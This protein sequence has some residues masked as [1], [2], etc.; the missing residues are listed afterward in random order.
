MNFAHKGQKEEGRS[1]HEN[2]SAGSSADEGAA[3]AEAA[4]LPPGRQYAG[5]MDLMA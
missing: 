4:Q 1:R 2:G 5:R 3:G